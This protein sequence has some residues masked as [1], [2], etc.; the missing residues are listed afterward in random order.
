VFVVTATASYV[1][2][3]CADNAT[4]T[5]N[6]PAPGTGAWSIVSSTGSPVIA[7]STAPSTT[8]TALGNGNN[9]IRWTVTGSA[10][11]VSANIIVNNSIPTTSVAG[12]DFSICTTAT[13]LSGNSP[14]YGTGAWTAVPNSIVFSNS[15]AFNSNVSNLSAGTNT[16]TWSITNGTCTSTD[17]LV[18]TV[19]TADASGTPLVTCD[20]T[21]DLTSIAAV[22]GTGSWSISSGSGTLVGIATN[23][24]VTYT[25]LQPNINIFRWTVT[26]GTCQVFDD[27][28]IDNDQATVANA[29]T[30]AIV[31]TYPVTLA[32]N[33][34][35]YGTGAWTSGTPGI[36]FANSSINNT[37]ITSGLADGLNTLTWTITNGTCVSTDNVD[38]T[39]SLPSAVNAGADQTACASTFTLAADAPMAGT[40]AWAIVSGSAT[41]V[42]STLHDTQVTIPQGTTRLRWTITSAGGCT[43]S[44]IVDITNNLPTASN[45]GFNQ[46]VC[47]R[48]ANLGGN[49]PTIGTGIWTTSGTAVI[50]NSTVRNTLVTN[51]T[52]DA[53]LFTWTITNGTC[54]SSDDVIIYSD[55]VTVPVVGVYPHTCDGDIEL[56]ANNPV[57]GT[58]TWSVT[59]GSGSPYFDDNTAYN[60]F[61]RDLGYDNSVLRWTI[62][63]GICSK[64]QEVTV[65]N[66]EIVSDAGSDRNICVDNFALEGN[67]PALFGATGTWTYTG[68]GTPVIANISQFNSTVTN[69]A[70]GDNTF[71]WTLNK[72][73]CISEDEVTIRNNIPDPLAYAGTDTVFCTYDYQLQGNVPVL[74]T[75]AWTLQSGSGTF[76]DNTDYNTWIRNLG[77]GDNFVV[78]S[79]TYNGCV[80]C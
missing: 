6:N 60:T 27:V 65:V 29:G 47:V 55:S 58:G 14:T 23:T 24:S 69:L 68:I 64:Y 8:V 10:C 39:Y 75:G 31:C 12:A 53:N 4:L 50:V 43:T 25:N 3:A 18:V 11:T 51:L 42:N 72:N 48:N 66:D 26:N 32:A 71:K 41:F 13:S 20:G 62:S 61:V 21:V 59:F 76:D 17:Q 7:N 56:S 80:S 57:L 77:Y 40:G 79:I 38:I 9:T 30:D 78:W 73:G 34:P 2:A 49:N 36:V 70:L 22:A 67:N 28:T 74:G 37:T 45:A 16:F 52:P 1:Q 46:T 5:G 44:D 15:T 19:L 35:V 63:K 33:N 54:T